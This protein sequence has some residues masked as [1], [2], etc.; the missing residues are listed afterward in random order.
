M[1]VIVIPARSGS[2]R[3]KDKNIKIL[4]NKPLITFL[5]DKFKKKNLK[6][7]IFVTSDSN[8]IKKI[9]SNYKNINF[10]K[11]PKKLASDLSKIEEALIHVINKEK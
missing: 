11:R 8:K 4:N 10:V 7:K 6:E 1:N 9:V 5:L 2:K 3:I